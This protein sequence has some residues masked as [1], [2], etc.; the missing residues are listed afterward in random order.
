[1]KTL[2][3][4]TDDWDH[5]QEIKTIDFHEHDLELT[6]TITSTENRLCDTEMLITLY[7]VII[8]RNIIPI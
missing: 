1:M 2:L 4:L 8:L 7:T 6:W 5:R 3:G